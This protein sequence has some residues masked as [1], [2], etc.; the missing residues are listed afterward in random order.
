[1]TMAAER[2]SGDSARRTKAIRD[3]YRKFVLSRLGERKRSLPLILIGGIV[4]CTVVLIPVGLYLVIRGIRG[5]PKWGP[6][7]DYELGFID[8]AEAVMAYPLMINS[9]LR[10]PGDAAA[11]GLFLIS[12]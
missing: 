7:L 5:R 12:F 2:T 6:A 4:M 9:M 11:A 1:M 8:R 3:R 10:R